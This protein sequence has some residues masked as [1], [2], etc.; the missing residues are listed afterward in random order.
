VGNVEALMRQ[1]QLQTAREDRI[2]VVAVPQILLNG[3]D[4]D[5]RGK[6]Q[7]ELTDGDAGDTDAANVTARRQRSGAE[8]TVLQEKRRNGVLPQRTRRGHRSEAVRLAAAGG[9]KRCKKTHI[10]T[11]PLV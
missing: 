8:V 7:R 1:Q 3:D 4:D 11:A 2:V 5:Q 6:Q 9:L 10:Q